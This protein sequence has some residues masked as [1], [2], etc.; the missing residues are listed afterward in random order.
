MRYLSLLCLLLLTSCFVV[1]PKGRFD[2]AARPVAPNYANPAHWSALPDQKDN[3]DLLVPSLS[4]TQ[5]DSEVDVFFLSP[6]IYTGAKRYQK[7][8]NAP[9]DLKKFNKDVD[10][11]AIKYQATIFNGVGRVYAP[12]YRQAHIRCYWIKHKDEDVKKAFD[13]AYEDVK[14]AFLYYLKNYNQ[15]RPIII[16]SHSQ[17]STHSTRL[18]KEFF[19]EKPLQNKLVVAYLIGMP[20]PKNVYNTISLCESAEQTGCYCAWRTFQK[21]YIPKKFPS[22]EQFAVTN[23]L[24]WKTDSTYAPASLNE[25]GVVKDFKKI[26]KGIVDA[27]I[28]NGMLWT[29]RPRFPGSFMFGKNFHA[30]DFNLFYMNIRNN[31]NYRKGLFWKR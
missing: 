3:A 26:R 30:G 25:G 28:H 14:T 8:W 1:S 17:G 29:K 22:G 16:A 10:N 23:P 19:D 21:G 18:L 7:N 2:D 15:G 27:Q 6:T 9:I 31:A 4:D 11:L 5:K 13:L 24:N 12:R 20:I